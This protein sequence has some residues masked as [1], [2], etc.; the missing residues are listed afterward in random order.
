M[1]KRIDGSDP[2]Y[3]RKT[4]MERQ[5]EDHRR[6]RELVYQKDLKELREAQYPVIPC[7]TR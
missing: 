2:D 4:E 3:F 6:D 7:H 5:K 1:R